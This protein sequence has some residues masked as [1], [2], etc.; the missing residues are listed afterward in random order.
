MSINIEDYKYKYE[1]HLHTSEGSK[2][3]ENTGAEMAR[4]HKEAGY[5]G[6][7]VTNHAWGGNTAVDVHLPYKEWVKEFA[8]GYY[9]ALEEGEKI[10]LQVFFGW[11]A[12]YDG[13]EFLIYGLSVEWM[14][15]HPQLWD[16][17]IEE[18]YKIV[19]DG[20]GA[21]M[22]PHP[23]REE[24]YIPEIRLF[25]EFVDGV[26]IANATHSSPLS[27]LYD[28]HDF[29]VMASMYANK[30]NLSVCGGSDV[31]TTKVL[32]GGTIFKKPMNKPEDFAEAFLHQGDYILADGK[33]YVDKK[34]NILGEINRQIN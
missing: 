13:T 30:N 33:S 26:E 12:G 4:A 10:G 20:G 3:A 25:P 17:S 19:H 21:V 31:H 8:K 11:E 9:A 23:F 22:H 29:D 16:A 1:M 14:L 28:H 34:G 24:W 15:A 2:C 18:Q 5:T 32:G 6:I 27:R 7:Y